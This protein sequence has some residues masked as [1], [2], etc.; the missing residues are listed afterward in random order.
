[1]LDSAPR[2]RR[3]RA[4]PFSSQCARVLSPLLAVLR[5]CLHGHGYL[6]QQDCTDALERDSVAVEW[7][8]W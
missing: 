2:Q 5:R 7:A 8:P 4:R 6:V 1:M 3:G